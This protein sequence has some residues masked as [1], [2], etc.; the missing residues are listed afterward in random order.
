MKF[1]QYSGEIAQGAQLDQKPA[2]T[3]GTVLVP[4]YETILDI[5]NQVAA[6]TYAVSHTIFAPTNAA[7]S[8]TWQIAGVTVRFGTASASA[9]LQV[10]VAGAGVAIAGGTNQLTGTISLAG[11][12]ATNANGT[13]NAAPTVFGAG[14]AINLIFAGTVT[15]LLNAVVSIDLARVS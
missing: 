14:A 10:E 9:T 3:A 12:P 11:T 15:G 8:S 1:S 4:L 2:N 13:L 5:Q 6:A 7:G